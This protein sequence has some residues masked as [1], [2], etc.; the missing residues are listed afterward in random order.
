MRE[1]IDLVELALAE[2]GR[3]STEMPPKLGI[4]PQP[5]A[6]LHAMPAFVRATSAA[7]VKWVGAFPGNQ[8]RGLPAVTGMIVLNDPETGLAQAIMDATWITATRTAASTAVAARKLAALDTQT[9]AII[10]PG[11]LGRANVAALREVLPG[12]KRVRAYAP[13]R[14]TVDRFARD[15]QMQHG[16]EVQPADSANDAARTAEVVVTAAPWPRVGGGPALGAKT[17]RNVRFCCALDF[18]STLSAGAI[19]AADRFFADDVGTF[20]SIRQGGFFP[21]WPAASELSHVV[22]GKSPVRQAP[23]ER[24]ICANLGLGIYD[25]VVARRVFETARQQGIGTELPL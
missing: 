5:G 15:I 11:V 21:N 13:R 1:V 12:L 24:V 23:D 8:K 7:G 22:A 4:H 14:E 10:G 6:L 25:V 18:D 16:L 20:E 17:M 9:L 19:A 2:H 3:G